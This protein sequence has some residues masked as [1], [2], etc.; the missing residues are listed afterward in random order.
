V[1]P[2]T[3]VGLSPLTLADKYFWWNPVP[4]SWES[5]AAPGITVMTPGLGYII[6]APQTFTAVP[7]VYP[8]FFSG[9]PNNGE[10]TIGITVNGVSDNN[11]LGNPYPSAID[12]D[13]MLS[14]SGPN[15]SVL[16]GTIYLWTHNTTITANQYNA[17]DF[18]MY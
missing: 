8:G 17:S 12:A 10:I 14:S 3:L 11:F 13:I 6:R 2:Q 9:V 15:A 5:I 1:F 7:Q 16:G 18:A 4:Y